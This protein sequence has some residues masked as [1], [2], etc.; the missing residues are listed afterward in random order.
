MINLLIKKSIAAKK[1]LKG[2]GCNTCWVRTYLNVSDRWCYKWMH[3]PAL[4]IC[5]HW[6]STWFSG[7]PTDK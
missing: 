6:H 3:K 7:E 2:Q 5:V 1:L 4:G